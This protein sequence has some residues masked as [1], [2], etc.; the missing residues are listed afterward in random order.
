M[1]APSRGKEGV[2]ESV[3]I[4]DAVQIRSEDPSVRGDASVELVPIQD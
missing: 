1:E 2:A 3:V 4:E